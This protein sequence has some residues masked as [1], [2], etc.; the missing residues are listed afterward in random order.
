MRKLRSVALV[1]AL[2]AVGCGGGGEDRRA[3]EPAPEERGPQQFTVTVDGKSDAFNGEFAAFFPNELSARP[4]DTVKFDMPE[5]SGVPHSVTF[6]KLVDEGLAKAS[7]LGAR[8][9]LEDQEQ[10]LGQLPDVFPH[11]APQ[12]P[13]SPNQ[14]AGQPCF[15]DSGAPPNSLSGGAPACPKREQPAFTGN[16]SFYNLGLL[17]NEGEFVSMPLADNIQPG[18]YGFICLIH[19]AGMAGKLTVAEEGAS[20]PSPAEVATRGRQQFD[21]IV[22]GLAPIAESAREASPDQANI[23]VLGD[24][25]LGFTIIAEFAPSEISVPVGGTV[26]WKMGSFHTLSFNARDSDIGVLNRDPDGTLRF[27]PRLAPAGFTVPRALGEFPPPENGTPVTVNLGSYDG[28]GFRSTGL[29]G[30]LPPRLVTLRVTFTRAGTVPVNC[31]VHP[32]MK[33]Q[34][35]VG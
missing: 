23:G 2:V 3:Q 31:L 13:P 34:V 11:E 5:F 26:T 14:S 4:G 9:S 20:V 1:L 27:S 21:Q 12:G 25:K 28:T 32:D 6:G 8:A 16:E 29:I 15:L 24:P 18:T 35:K 30:S 33:G 22:Q 19:R 17:L 10:V 7:A